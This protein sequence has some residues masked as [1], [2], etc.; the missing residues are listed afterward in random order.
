MAHFDPVSKIFYGKEIPQVYN[1]SSSLGQVM[2]F[3]FFRAPEK[4]IQV[5]HEDKSVVTCLQMSVMMENIAQSLHKLGFRFGDVAGLLATNT[6][7]VAPTIFACFLLGLPVSPLD[8]SFHVGQIVRIYR[9]TKPKLV[10]C[11]HDKAEKLIR[12]LEILKSDATVI[13][14]TERLDNLMHISD[15]I[16]ETEQPIKL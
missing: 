14:L 3:N 1:P 7:F 8:V 11:D 2:L 9:E 4:V 6:T 16:A 5:S 10:F 13:I 12:A 15:L